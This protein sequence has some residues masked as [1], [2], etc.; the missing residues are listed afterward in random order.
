MAEPARILVSGDSDGLI[1]ALR[2]AGVRCAPAPGTGARDYAE[3]W[4]YSHLL[5]V[6][7]QNG[8]RWCAV[9]DGS[10]TELDRRDES[11]LVARLLTL[12]G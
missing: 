10:R 2:R 7:T 1:G 8:S 5:E 12:L 4:R 9:T 3:A 6:Q 11:Q